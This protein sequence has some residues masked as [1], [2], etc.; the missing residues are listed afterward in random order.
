VKTLPIMLIILI[1]C[2]KQTPD[3]VA[4]Y[5]NMYRAGMEHCGY[6]PLEISKE[7]RDYVESYDTRSS[8]VLIIVNYS[9]SDYQRLANCSLSTSVLATIV[10]PYMIG[11]CTTLGF[12]E[13]YVN[14][15]LGKVSGDSVVIYP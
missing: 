10:D 14:P 5:H 9:K 6:G 11:V 2:K 13:T 3:N 12:R 1:G 4:L 8:E 15:L 7:I